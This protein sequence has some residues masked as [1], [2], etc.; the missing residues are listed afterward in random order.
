MI[1]TITKIS[2]LICILIAL[3]FASKSSENYHRVKIH[4]EGRQLGELAELGLALPLSGYKEGMFLQG[5]FSETELKKITDA[6]FT[7]E[8]V[9][10]D[11]SRY[12]QQRNANVD[13]ERVNSQMHQSKNNNTPYTTP[14]N[15]MLGSMGGFHTYTEMLDDLDA[16]HALYPELISAKQSIGTGLTIEGRPVF[17]VRISNNPSE[18]QD[19]PRVLYTSLTHAREP[20]SMQ[21]MLFQM[22]YILENYDTDP[23]I[24]YLVDNVEMYF[25]PCVNPDGYI[26]CETTHPNGGS[27]HRKNK[28][29]NN[30]G[31]IGVDLNRNYGYMWGYDNSGSSPVPSSATYRGTGPFSEPETQIQK[32]FAEEFNFVLALNNHTYS[33]I[34]IYPWGYNSQQTPDGEI[35]REYAKLMTR[36]NN[37]AYG[38]CY[39]TLGYVANGG[40]DDW[41]YGEQLTKDKTFA[42]TPEAGKPSDGFW[43]QVHRIE[44]ICAGHMHMNLSLA[45]LALA[46]AQIRDISQPFISDLNPEIPFEIVSMG[47]NIDATYTVSVNPLSS[48]IISTGDPQV[49][50]NMDVL[51]VQQSTFPLELHPNTSAGAPVRFVVSLNNGMY[52]WNDTITKF[53]GEPSVAFSDACDNTN[54]WTTT[55]WNTTTQ[56]YFSS[57]ASITDSPGQDYANSSNTH[58]TI[59]QPFDFSNVGM[60]WAEF[61]IRYDIEQNWDYVQFLYSINGQQTWT[62]L[63]GELTATGGSNQDSGQ[64]LYH[65]TQSQWEKERIDLS[66]LAGHEEVW[67]RFRL[68]S[69]NLVTEDGFYF[70]DFEIFTLE[71][72]TSFDHYIPEE[73]SFYQHQQITLDLDEMTTWEL[74][75]NIQVNWE[76]NENLDIES[77]SPTTFTITNTDPLWT[78]SE[79]ILLSL[80]DDLYGFDHSVTFHVLPVP[81]PVITGQQAIVTAPGET[82]E[83]TPELISVDDSFFSYPN[84]FTITLYPGENYSIEQDH[85]IVPDAGF[86]GMLNVGLSVN[87]GFA[88]SEV[89]DLEVLVGTETGISELQHTPVAY[90]DARNHQL[91]FR[92]TS[93]SGE[94]INFSLADISGRVILSDQVQQNSTYSLQQ[95]GKGVYIV[96]FR[97]G[98]YKS[99]KIVVL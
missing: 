72:E 74:Q 22:W 56:Q 21:Q 57:P 80:Q 42:F 73:I 54:N 92:Q 66:H 11:M 64:P 97:D 59:G 25:V 85:T 3:P 68:V 43:P 23:E 94:R 49:F 86:E 12:Y 33:D 48:N 69:D 89:F 30:D 79:G 47:Q 67:L 78:G 39:E 82:L 75:G 31:T 53:F 44:E 6:G 58:I 32:Q 16:M 98:R 96:L 84:D 55:S 34:L 1:R 52:T 7:Y 15:F 70:D 40:S 83:F 87:N 60:A 10:H 41:F 27:M 99:F 36:E 46:Y 8:V 9:I 51:E 24:Q 76:G 50:S 81:A 19:K 95:M 38:T 91:V 93:N 61:Y 45:H 65:G 63:E 18:T 4:L 29:V 90:Y 88:E 77:D 37:Y 71:T 17:W 13:I 35:F 14:E 20:A 62:P 28:R 2:L 5:E 26:F